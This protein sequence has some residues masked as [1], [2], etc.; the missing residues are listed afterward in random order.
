MAFVDEQEGVVGDIFEEGRRRLARQAAGQ[1]AA[2]VL[3]AG[4]GSG[5][6]DHLQV[7]H[8]ALFQALGLQQLA[9]GDQPVQA[10]LELLLDAD[11]GL[12]QGR[13][14]RHIVAVRIDLDRGQ[15]AGLLAGQG[16]ELHDRLDLVAE[17]GDAPGAVLIVGGKDLD[18][19]AAA[20]EGAPLEGRIVALVLLGH[21]VGH[22][23]AL[24]DLLPHLQ[25]EGH[26]GIGLDR[27]DA[28][29]AGDRGHHDD[30]VALEDRPGGRVAHAVDLLVDRAV[31]FY[32]GVGARDIGLGLVIVVIAD[33]IF[34]AVVGE[35]RLEL[36]IELGRQGLVGGQD[37]G[38]A[39][40]GLD[41]L[42]HGEGLAGPRNAQQHLVALAALQAGDDV[43]DGGGLVA[44]RLIVRH[45]PKPLAALRLFRPHRPVR[46][47]Q[48]R[49]EHGRVLDEARGDLPHAWIGDITGHGAKGRGEGRGW[50][51]GLLTGL[52]QQ[53]GGREGSIVRRTGA[54]SSLYG[55]LG[56]AMGL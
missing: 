15:V 50:L 12:A 8:G 25:G 55:R 22:Q 4:A 49:L 29:D 20:A 23:L 56:A 11:G 3:D 44:G 2:V 5:G 13:A 16:I 51:G 27:A 35:K 34:D 6:L 52:C 47:P 46:G 31:F 19:V 38:R 45:H 43:G 1:I 33:E 30:V 28:V 53:S 41:H 40:G 10:G 54:P 26:G 37:Q 36:A 17:H 24:V 18:H 42:G 39:L 9:I 48:G 21:Q 7:E 32:V 14:R